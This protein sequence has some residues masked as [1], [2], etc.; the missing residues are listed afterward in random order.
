VIGGKETMGFWDVE[1]PGFAIRRGPRWLTIDEATGLLS[2]T[3]DR[4]GP[5]E[6]VVSATLERDARRLDEAALKWGVE[7]VVSSGTEAAGTAS[8]SF[9]IDV[10]P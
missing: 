3:P 8:Q 7:K 2:G 4:A 10:R 5:A 1:R 9:V 6:V